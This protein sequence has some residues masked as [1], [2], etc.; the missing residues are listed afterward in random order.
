MSPQRTDAE[1]WTE[2]DIP[3]LSGQTAVV[4]GANTGLGFETARA[5]A[6]RG[7]AVV[8]AAGTSARRT[9]RPRVSARRPPARP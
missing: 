9:T 5:L 4:T 3:Q 6:A 1:H 7:A 8:L 2:A